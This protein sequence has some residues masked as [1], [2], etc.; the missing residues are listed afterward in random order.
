MTKPKVF[1]FFGIPGS[2][3]SYLG[4]KFAE[5][6]NLFF[7]EADDDFERFRGGLELSSEDEKGK[8]KGEFYQLVIGNIQEFLKERGRVVGASALGTDRYRRLF[9][10]KFGNSVLFIFVKPD[11]HK[12]LNQVFGRELKDP[13]NKNRNPKELKTTLS[14]HLEKKYKSFETPTIDHLVIE[15]NYDQ[16]S[17]TKTLNLI[18]PYL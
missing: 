3:K 8:I 7:Y 14:K 11:F 13:Q 17:E 6:H 10:D 5:R 12:H 15:N 4:K 1:V 16:V 9:L 2:G 18:S